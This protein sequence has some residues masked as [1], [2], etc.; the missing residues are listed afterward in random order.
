MT[1]LDIQKKLFDAFL[2]LDTF[3]SSQGY[4]GEAFLEIDESK[5]GYEQFVNVHFPNVPFDYP[6]DKRW[7]DLDFASG[8]PSDVALMQGSQSRFAGVFYIDIIV[9]QD[10]A[11]LEAETKYK[12]IAK[13]FHNVNIDVVDIMQVYIS[14]KGNDA[15]HYRL[16]VA[17]SWEADINKE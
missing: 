16:Q 14:T 12:W 8:E 1:E 15:D 7:F 17:V 13:L 4:T 2:T 3:A 10:V 5:T 9:P 6:D 11:E